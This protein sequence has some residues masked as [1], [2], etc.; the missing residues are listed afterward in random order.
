MAYDVTEYLTP[1]ETAILVSEMQEGTL[2]EQA[3]LKFLRES[4]I[5]TGA[6]SNLSSLLD[7][8]R[9]TDGINIFHCTAERRADGFADPVNSPMA[10]MLIKRAGPGWGLESGTP[11]AEPL[12]ELYK[13]NSGS[14]YVMSRLI[15]MSPFYGTDLDYFLRHSGARNVVLTGASL[16]VAVVG[17]AIEA[18]NHGYN[19][20]LAPDCTVCFPEEY[21][22]QIITNTLSNLCYLSTAEEII[23]F[24]KG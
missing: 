7:T 9:E 2:G 20:V 22:E 24:W 18:V 5:S 14:D 11:K 13:E 6:L 23:A 10:K 1:G 19:V 3:P 21:A 4:A 17:M 15:G 8:A 16:N 12:A